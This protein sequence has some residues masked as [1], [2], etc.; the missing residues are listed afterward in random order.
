MLL[1]VFKLTI[2]SGVDGSGDGGR[3]EAVRRGGCCFSPLM[4][5]VLKSFFLQIQ[6]YSIPGT[7]PVLV[8]VYCTV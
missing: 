2:S 6:L 5:R 4:M 7:V 3:E 8:L 1:V